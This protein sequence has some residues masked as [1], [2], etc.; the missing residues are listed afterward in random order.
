MIFILPA[1]FGL[2]GKKSGNREGLID[3]PDS[4]DRPTAF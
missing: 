1:Y 3:D 4:P 2:T